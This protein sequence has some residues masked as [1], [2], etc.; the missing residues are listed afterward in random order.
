[1]WRAAGCQQMEMYTDRGGRCIFPTLTVSVEGLRA[2][3]TYMLFLDLMPKDQN[4]CTYQSGRWLPSGTNRP[5]PPP[6]QGE[7]ASVESLHL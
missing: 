7:C 4:V 1:M 2:D 5:Y 3:K 6:N